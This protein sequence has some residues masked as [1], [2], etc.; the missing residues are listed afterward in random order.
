MEYQIRIAPPAFDYGEEYFFQEYERQYGKTYL[1]DMTHLRELAR[2]RIRCIER[3]TS[4]N[5][6]VLDVGCAYGA[7]LAE[8]RGREWQVMGT[9][10]SPEAC[11]YVRKELDF[12]ARCGDFAE[13]D[14][15]ERNAFSVVSMWYVIEH[16]KDLRPVLSRVNSVL[17]EGGLFCFSTP[18]A[19]G[20]SRRKDAR[21]FFSGSPADHYTLWSEKNMRKALGLHGFEVLRVRVTG[22]HPERFPSL[23]GLRS[24]RWISKALSIVLRLGD[25]FEIYARKLT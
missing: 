24:L 18:N 21:A 16:F 10:I 3:M 9:D 20:I 23:L 8:A 12:P 4:G 1:D 2:E 17:S 5:Q 15:L 22:H 11:D 19:R 7:F 13:M 25:T 6:R 14:D